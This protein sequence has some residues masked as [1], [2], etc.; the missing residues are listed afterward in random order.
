MSCFKGSLV[1][2]ANGTLKKIE[3]LQVGDEVLDHEK[4]TQIVDGIRV[5]HLVPFPQR[6]TIKI[7]DRYVIT[8]RHCILTP[9]NHF[10]QVDDLVA[11]T[12]WQRLYAYT[13]QYNKIMFKW[14]WGLHDTPDLCGELTLNS[15]MKTIDGCERVS[16]L[17]VIDHPDDTVFIHSVTGS[18]TYFVNGICITARLNESWDYRSMKPYTERVDIVSVPNHLGRLGDFRRVFNMDHSKND[19][20][21]WDYSMSHFV[22]PRYEGPGIGLVTEW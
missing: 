6:K 11:R 8:D 4:N 12:K 14:L 10:R 19:Y 20:P 5:V 16:K 18:G 3:E 2:M 1:S 9:E 13:H 17:E 21:Y 22:Q 15:D 7:N